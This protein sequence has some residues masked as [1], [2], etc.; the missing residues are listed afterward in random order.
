VHFFASDGFSRFA[1]VSYI[2]S[3]TI[4]G[5]VAEYLGNCR[6]AI[7]KRAQVRFE[8]GKLYKELGR[9]DSARTTFQQ[10]IQEAGESSG[11]GSAAKQEL[12]G[13]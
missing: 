8:I 6:A 9:R 7:V 10:V 5:R 4:P 12:A 3:I 1:C 11:V 2:D 13:L